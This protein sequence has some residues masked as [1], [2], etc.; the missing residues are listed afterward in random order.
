MHAHTNIA[1]MENLNASQKV[2]NPRSTI[3]MLTLPAFL[4]VTFMEASFYARHLFMMLGG[5]EKSNKTAKVF[6]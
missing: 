2:N 6:L 1:F 3:Y 5:V 4:Q